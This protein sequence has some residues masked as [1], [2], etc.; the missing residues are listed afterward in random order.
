VIGATRT[1]TRRS[2]SARSRLP[3]SR[4][5]SVL[6]TKLATAPTAATTNPATPSHGSFSGT[7]SAASA[8]AVARH[9]AS[10]VLRRFHPPSVADQ[11]TCRP[12]RPD[13]RR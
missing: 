8:A 1:L 5:C 9:A 12:Y 10:T 3:S 11:C 13:Y 2:S 6:I 4:A 7:A